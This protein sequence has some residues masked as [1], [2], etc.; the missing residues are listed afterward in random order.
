MNQTPSSRREF[1]IQSTLLAAGA[2]MSPALRGAT[3]APAPAP[4][5]GADAQ[6]GLEF[7]RDFLFGVASAAYQIEGAWNEDGKG[8]S[9]WDR[10][11]HDGR[12]QVTG[13]VAADHFHRYRE[14]IELLRAL[15]VGV[16]RF[17]IAW[18][19]IFPRGKG[20]L[21]PAGLAF[22]QDLVA[23]LKAAGIRPA[24]TLYHWDLPQALE[25]EG[26]WAN[27]ETA[28]HFETYA[29]TLFEHLGADVAY[30]ITFNEPWVTTL[31]GYWLGS[32]APGKKDL[33]TALA[34]AHNI[35]RAHGR[36]VGAFREMKCPGRIGITLDLFL[37]R[38]ATPDPGDQRAAEMINQSHL[39]WF[40][41]PI[42]KGTY[43]DMVVEQYRRHGY[44]VPAMTDGDRRLIRQPVDFVGVNYY[45]S[46]TWRHDPKGGWAPYEATRVEPAETRALNPDWHPEGLT[47]LLQRL[48]RDYAG[49]DLLV[50]ENG[51]VWS[52]FVNN[53][54]VVQ[55]DARIEFLY[56]HL[57]ACR[58][59]LELGVNLR[60]YI[61]WSF[62]DDYEWG[63]FGRLGLV[64]VDFQTLKRTIKQSGYWYRDSIARNRFA[65]P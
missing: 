12:G 32:M 51:L 55:D 29:R 15:G 36:A 18:T 57:A 22:Y 13:D 59:A 24:V 38:P 26:G 64:H 30:W 20:P 14:D 42:F 48:H 19:R 33:N 17:S 7:P 8:E 60:G 31:A 62:L 16:Y 35:L 61:V 34:A 40:A 58:R 9:I 43:P 53:R 1:L 27:P 25:D 5:A 56:R 4:E 41:D 11:S 63:S 2:A 6:A 50:T 21:N 46:D 49:I 54:G 10:W 52:D 3:P 37:G 45:N 23:R 44:A 65:L 39:N 47:L 28:A